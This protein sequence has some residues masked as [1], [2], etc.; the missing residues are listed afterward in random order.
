MGLGFKQLIIKL[1]VTLGICYLSLCITLYFLQDSLLFHPQPWSQYQDKLLKRDSEGLKE[2]RLKMKDNTEIHGILRTNQNSQ[3]IERVFLAFGGNA[4]EAALSAS[5]IPEKLLVGSVWIS[6]NYRGYGKS[7]GK[8]SQ[9]SFYRDSLEI[10]EYVKSN[11]P[12]A[13]LV[14]WGRSLGSGVATFLASQK[15]IDG[16]VL[17]SP[18]SS[19]REIARH[20]YPLFPIWLVLN[21]PFEM[22]EY[23]S[24]IQQK[25]LCL[26]AEEDQIIPPVYSKKYW[27]NRCH[28]KLLDR[29]GHNDIYFHP[30]F[31]NHIEEYLNSIRGESHG[32]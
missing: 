6:F 8:P 32:N 19:I 26:V 9:E 4:D 21:N 29:S 14:L 10:Y 15:K 18:Y 23:V 25:P 17:I 28:M 30:E 16:L 12:E 20:H 7:Q 13:K 2:I 22:Q 3:P 5:G 11:Y 27:E 24:S 31:W 1:L